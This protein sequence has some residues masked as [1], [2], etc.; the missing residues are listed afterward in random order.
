VL[1]A[2][3]ARRKF[4]KELRMSELSGTTRTVVVRLGAIGTI[5]RGIVFAV[6]GAL[7]VDAAVTA[8]AAKSIGLDGALRTLA[9]R[10]HRPWILGAFA[11][12][13]I[14]FGLFGL[15]QARWAKT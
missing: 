7:V 13:L 14:A 8:D 9:D 11:I 5:A 3:R 2:I 1:E 6:A 4:E 15:A 10:P 12:G